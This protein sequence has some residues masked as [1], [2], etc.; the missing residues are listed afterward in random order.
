[1]V[2]ENGFLVDDD[3]LSR[4]SGDDQEDMD[5][6]DNPECLDRDL[7]MSD[8]S[9]QSSGD[10]DGDGDQDDTNPGDLDEIFSPPRFLIIRELLG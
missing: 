8:D 2:D 9:S 1:M 10:E 6:L 3:A 4:V 7:Y 5:D